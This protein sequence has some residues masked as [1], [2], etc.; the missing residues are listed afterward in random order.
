MITIAS[1]GR[2]SLDDKL[3]CAFALART[4]V[5][6]RQPHAILFLRAITPKAAVLSPT[7]ATLASANSTDPML[8]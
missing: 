4:P 3:G 8:S 5:C 1:K 6:R 7:P 2:G